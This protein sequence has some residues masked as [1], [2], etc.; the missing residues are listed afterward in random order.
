MQW[1]QVYK[2]IILKC[3]FLFSN[4][5]TYLSI[6]L[7]RRRKC[8]LFYSRIMDITCSDKLRHS[9]AARAQNHPHE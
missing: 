8:I 9:A 6:S 7:H 2:V 3:Q 1:Y 4:N 5:E